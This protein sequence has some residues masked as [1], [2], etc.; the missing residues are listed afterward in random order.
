[1]KLDA[2]LA[3]VAAC[4]RDGAFLADVGTD[5]AY[6]PIA[7]TEAGRLSG[8]VASD[9]RRGPIASAE[10]N[11]RAAGL[12]GRIETRLCDGL[13]GMEALPL[14]DIVIAGMGGQMIASILERVAFVREKKTYLVLQPMQNVVELREY[15]SHGY[16]ILRETL[17]RE[18]DKLYQI[19]CVRYDGCEHPLTPLTAAL[20]AYLIEHKTEMQDDFTLL[21]RRKLAV[22]DE[23]IRGLT[24]GG[25]DASAERELRDAIAAELDF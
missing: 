3:A 18:G 8:A 13:D 5:H 25:R 7:L 22:L 17:V 15:L 6:L 21:C 12:A 10:K 23:R 9:V 1:M 14:T 19:L 2:R 16:D 24:G 4:V 20:G 11:I